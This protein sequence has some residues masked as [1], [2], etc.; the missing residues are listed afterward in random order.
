MGVPSHV[1]A[2][3][4]AEAQVNDAGPDTRRI[5]CRAGHP[6]GQLG[7]GLAAEAH[8]RVHFISIRRGKSAPRLPQV[9]LA[10]RFA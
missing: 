7:E 5:E 9:M 3:K 8:A 6:R 2:V 4:S 10:A 1:C